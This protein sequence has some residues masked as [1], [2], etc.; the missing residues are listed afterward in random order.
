ML[1][2]KILSAIIAASMI[3]SAMPAFAYDQASYHAKA[4]ELKA[5]IAECQKLGI[6]TQYEE[7]D[8]N[9]I[10]VY[11][12]R[13]AEFQADGIKSSISSFQ[14]TEL[15]TLYANAKANLTAYKAGTKEAPA[16]VETYETGDKYSI[17]GAS[18]ENTYGDPYFSAGFGHFGMSKYI[19]ELNIDVYDAYV[20]TYEPETDD[21]EIYR[22]R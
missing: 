2:K 18:L 13:I 8:A 4:D 1:K 19:K 6:N 12:D 20:Y 5:L 16:V 3:C 21:F 15:D 10:E 22:N 17:N 14:L 7:I 11:A 9:I